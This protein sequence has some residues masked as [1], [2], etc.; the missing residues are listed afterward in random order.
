MRKRAKY[1]IDQLGRVTLEYNDWSRTFTMNGSYVY[2][3]MKDGQL[4]QVCDGL[5]YRGN[6]L[7]CIEKG[8][9]LKELIKYE[10]DRLRRKER[11]NHW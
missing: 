6:T 2:E 5:S 8:Q 1:T 9:P 11:K 10:F 4:Q 3:I 7:T